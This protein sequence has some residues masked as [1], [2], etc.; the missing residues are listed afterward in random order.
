MG[1]GSAELEKV[2]GKVATMYDS[3]PIPHCVRNDTVWS[4]TVACC[5]HDFAS[6]LHVAGSVQS[7]FAEGYVDFVAALGPGPCAA[8]NGSFSVIYLTVQLKYYGFGLRKMTTLSSGGLY[9]K[10]LGTK[11]N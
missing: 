6:P 3:Q 9:A 8:C 11:N 1:N 4:G 2:S 5:V 10:E 7:W